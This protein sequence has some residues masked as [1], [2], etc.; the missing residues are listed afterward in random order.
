MLCESGAFELV[1]RLIFI[2]LYGFGVLFY[3]ILVYNLVKKL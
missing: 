2:S 3:H 1:S